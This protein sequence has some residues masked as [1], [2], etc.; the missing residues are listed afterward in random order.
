RPIIEYEQNIY[1]GKEY[2]KM[3]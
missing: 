2:E 1:I 3:L